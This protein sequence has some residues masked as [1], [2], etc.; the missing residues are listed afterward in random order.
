MS[1]ECQTGC[2]FEP[3]TSLTF[4]Q[5]GPTHSGDRAFLFG[6]NS[7]V[8]TQSFLLASADTA[9]R[10][11]PDAVRKGR[12]P[13]RYRRYLGVSWVQR[14]CDSGP[15][16]PAQPGT[17]SVP[18]WEASMRTGAALRSKSTDLLPP[19][20]HQVTPEIAG[21]VLCI[22]RGQKL[23]HVIRQLVQAPQLL[24]SVKNQTAAIGTTTSS[25]ASSRSSTLRSSQPGRAVTT[26]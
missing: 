16:Q 19:F 21:R 12:A 6:V 22:D 24:S 9:Q 2:G 15:Y 13:E 11:S 14:A 18:N 1:V 8:L 17:Y 4:C 23:V 26:P 25:E 5:R 20:A 3:K 10:H 7:F